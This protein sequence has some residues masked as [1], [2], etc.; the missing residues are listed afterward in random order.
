MNVNLITNKSGIY[1]YSKYDVTVS[2]Y[3]QDKS[4]LLFVTRGLVCGG[5]IT[6]SP[7]AYQLS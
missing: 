5:E 2:K 3:R 6:A 4:H 1:F 7:P